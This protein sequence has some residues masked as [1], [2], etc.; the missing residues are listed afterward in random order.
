V[1]ERYLDAL[2]AV[3]NM[4]GGI[5]VPL[6]SSEHACQRQRNV[7]N[8]SASLIFSDVLSNIEAI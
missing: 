4:I 7:T 1:P 8:Q 3:V 6:P 5:T 2:P